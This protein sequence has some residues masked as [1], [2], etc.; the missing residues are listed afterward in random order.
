M[1]LAQLNRKFRL[2]LVLRYSEGLSYEEIARV[3]SISPGTVA[4]R[5]SRAHVRL[6]EILKDFAPT[7]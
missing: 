3:L 6:A 2:P 5:L 7:D 4:S 1:A